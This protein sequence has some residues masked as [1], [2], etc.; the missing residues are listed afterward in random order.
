MKKL[1]NT[2]I[3]TFSLKTVKKYWHIAFL[4]LLSLTPVVW[5]IGKGDALINGVDTNFPLNPTLWLYRRFYMWNNLGNGGADFSFAP[6]GIFFHLI[7]F[8]PGL[9][10]LSLQTIEKLSLVF[11]FGLMVTTSYV[12]S[13]NFVR[14][15]KLLRV[16]F[17]CLYTVNIYMF[18]S[19]ENVKVANLSLVATIPL[20][21]H[22]FISL[23][24]GVISYYKAGILL[25]LTSLILSGAGINPAYFIAAILS[26]F[27]YV[28]SLLICGEK[29][30]K[31]SKMFLFVTG[32]ILVVGSYWVIP[33][34]SFVLRNVSQNASIGSIGFNNWIDS[35]SENTSIINIL[36][37]QG[38]W[39]W[40]SFDGVSKAP[41]FLPYTPNY[42]FK[43]PF[44]L[45][46]FVVPA[47]S[48][49]SLAF[50]NKNKIK[51]YISFL[52]M[53]L[54]GVFLGS[55]SHEP[56][57]TL[58]KWLA[59]YVPYFSL[60]RSPWY[61]FTPILTLSL[62]GLTVLLFDRFKSSKIL[63]SLVVLLIVSNVV[64]CYPLITGRI[65]RPSKPDGFFV[66]FPKYPFEAA[67]K[68]SN[69]TENR[70]IS[71]PDD[72][73][74]KLNW[75]Y[76]GVEPVIN[77][78][79]NNEMIY[80]GINNTESS[81]SQIV[82]EFYAKIKIGNN[83]AAQ[84]LA[85]KLNADT[86]LEKKDQQ[87]LAPKLQRTDGWSTSEFGEWLIH[88]VNSNP[89]TNR[90]ISLASDF[91]Y[92][93]G[94][95]NKYSD[96]ISLLTPT[97]NLISPS[98]S[99][100]DKISEYKNNGGIIISSINSLDNKYKVN[101]NKVDDLST[102][103][104]ELSVPEDGEYSPILEKYGVTE[105]LLNNFV[106]SSGTD[107]SKWSV[108][109]I[110][111]S[112]IY[113]R[114]V[115]IK[116]GDYK[117]AINIP[118]SQNMIQLPDASR[119]DFSI[120]NQTQDDKIV[121][122]EIPDFDPNIPYLISFDYSWSYGNR[123]LVRITQ[124]NDQ[125][126]FKIQ[127]IGLEADV[128]KAKHK[129]YFTPVQTDSRALV[130]FISAQT[131]SDKGTLVNYGNVNIQKL[132]TN[133]LYFLKDSR[134]GTDIA[135]IEFTKISPVRYVG[136]VKNVTN[137]QTLVF[138]DN[139]SDGWKIKITDLDGN[140]IR[141]RADHFSINLYANAW[142]IDTVN[143]DFKFEI[144]YNPQKYFNIGVVISLI[145]IAMVIFLYLINKKSYVR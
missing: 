70:T 34:I 13:G 10:E 118:T 97:Q 15:N 33:T 107:S 88:D 68:L 84:N 122:F 128:F 56:T 20:L 17:V 140:D 23:K 35:L 38:A 24:D 21:L 83:V 86:I 124:K 80:S 87:T 28:L 110:D 95:E 47:I 133:K 64:Y 115:F 5:F 55:G 102:V 85:S 98:D 144:Y 60:F 2:E 41:L 143:K 136:T 121:D 43:T 94:K 89:N 53:L 4:I 109:N 3:M 92:S 29:F 61:I 116:K 145:S 134:K 125:T 79:S 129:L 69:L 50:I 44:I 40:Y 74:E 6:A 25:I 131:N 16:L 103:I 100:V 111:D 48:L 123:P 14:E 139:Y 135:N 9:V 104:F 11:W 126:Y 32:I 138:A 99:I 108:N 54:V 93:Y 63:N 73:L 106:L 26:L 22:I 90:K 82:N 52:L 19:W 62:S 18:N 120:L 78:F 65:F 137:P 101:D 141:N 36:R 39:D 51:F 30:S 105:E 66:N 91:Y 49:I 31:L 7:Q 71:Y 114:K 72:Q 81:F 113:F 58:F 132:F 117:Y 75:G 119:T 45:F 59:T 76:I 96:Q 8:L 12:F 37:L 67:N 130:S 57:G 27:I 142:Y 127:N 42:F 1:I 46:S 112:Y 77:L